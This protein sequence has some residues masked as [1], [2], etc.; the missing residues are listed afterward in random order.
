MLKG[1]RALSTILTIAFM[2]GLGIPDAHAQSLSE[3]ERKAR[4]MERQLEGTT[5]MN[6]LLDAFQETMRLMEQAGRRVDPATSPASP[7]PASTPEAES[8]RQRE[9]INSQFRIARNLFAYADTDDE[10]PLLQEALA[11]EGYILVDGGERELLTSGGTGKELAYAIEE[12]FVGNL[13]VGRGFDQATGGFLQPSDYAIQTLSTDI[14]LLNLLGKQCVRRASGGCVAWTQFIRHEVEPTE[15]YPGFSDGVVSA[16]TDGRQVRIEASTPRMI[17]HGD[18]RVTSAGVGCFS[19]DWTLDRS[20]FET[21][22]ERGELLLRKDMRRSAGGSPG[23][24]P[25]SSMLLLIYL[26]DRLT[27]PDTRVCDNQEVQLVVHH[28]TADRRYVYTDAHPLTPQYDK[29]VLELDAT[30]V[31]PEHADQIVWT[32][33]DI[34]GATR[35]IS[36][37]PGS[38][39][40]KGARLTVT[41][42]GLPEDYREFGKRTI[43]ASVALDSCATKAERDVYFFYPRDARNNP[44]REHP[45]WFYF[46]RQTPAARPFGY[47]DVRFG[48]TEYDLCDGEHQ[49]AAYKPAH[50]FKAI[51]ICDLTEKLGGDFTVT[52][53]KVSRDDLSTLLTMQYVSYSHIDTFA[54]LVIHEFTHF[55]NFHT[56]WEHKTPAQRE[57][58]DKDGDGIPDRLERDMGFDPEEFQTHWYHDEDFRN[59]NGDEEFLAYESTY[60]YQVGTHD[61]HDW[62][63]PGKNWTD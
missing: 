53:P 24:K 4:E 8:A 52:L 25:G 58:E 30:T 43:T 36:P 46:W 21:L 15:R 2:A 39:K 41:Y 51:H 27:Q 50:L 23:C 7:F 6:Q 9:I 31:P 56:W 13:I 62:G 17:F 49:M 59:I 33:P 37:D 47:V 5:D 19:A 48:G 10:E 63:K 18:D 34:D 32:I 22:L 1:L 40:P 42:E 14:R 16:V 38:A 61:A 35:K 3:L 55:N 12:K 54:V 29:L 20:D 57:E 11:I 44:G 45:N 26:K 60:S 28:P